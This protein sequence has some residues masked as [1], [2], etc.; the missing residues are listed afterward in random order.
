MLPAEGGGERFR[1]E[2]FYLRVAEAE[3]GQC[4]AQQARQH[5]RATLA[6]LK[7]GLTGRVRPHR[8]NC[9]RTTPTCWAPNPCSTT[10]PGQARVAHR[11]VRHH[12]TARDAC[13]T[14]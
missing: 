12:A 11:H 13:R 1:V 4:T 9:P 6:A 14:G 5:A 8:R 7:A 3:G 10:E 2:D